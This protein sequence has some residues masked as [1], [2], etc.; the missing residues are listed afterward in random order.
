MN[1]LHLDIIG[2]EVG[3]GEADE[4]E[5]QPPQIAELQDVMGK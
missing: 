5:A 2:A 3:Q 4:A 1:S